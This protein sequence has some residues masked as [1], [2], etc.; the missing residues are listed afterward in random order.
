MPRQKRAAPTLAEEAAPTLAERVVTTLERVVK[1][2]EEEKRLEHEACALRADVWMR[3]RLVSEQVIDGRLR[4]AKLEAEYAGLRTAAACAVPA[5]AATGAAVRARIEAWIKAQQPWLLAQGPYDAVACDVSNWLPTLLDPWVFTYA[6][7]SVQRHKV[8]LERLLDLLLAHRRGRLAD[9]AGL[10][11]GFTVKAIKA[12]GRMCA[13]VAAFLKQGHATLSERLGD[14]LLEEGKAMPGQGT[15][16]GATPY[17]GDAPLLGKHP[18]TDLACTVYERCGW[19]AE[20]NLDPEAVVERFRR[21]LPQWLRDVARTL[22]VVE[23][24]VSATPWETAH[25]DERSVFWSG[26][27]RTQ[28]CEAQTAAAITALFQKETSGKEC[29][30]EVAVFTYAVHP[31]SLAAWKGSPRPRDHVIQLLASYGLRTRKY[32]LR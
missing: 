3:Y 21:E 12:R 29:L 8:H 32:R 4:I 23:T 9:P 5:E 20:K 16:E 6:L 26:R 31:E 30:D 17:R 27:R 24:V 11:H 18:V 2:L 1:A 25:L 22:E 13:K 14:A 15:A 10:F 28:W 19:A 7:R